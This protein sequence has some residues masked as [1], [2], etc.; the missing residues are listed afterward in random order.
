MK[1]HILDDWFDTLKT[2]PCF[3]RLAD[4]DV[5]IW[6]DHQP[7]PVA[8]AKRV[9][10]AEAL[11]LFRERTRIGADLLG[12]LPK[13]KLISQRSVYPHVDVDACTANGVL[14]CSNMHS[15]TP[16]Y[17]AAEHTLALILASYRQ[18]PQQSASLKAGE[19]QSGV[20]RTLRG[21][22]LGLY[23]YGRIGRAVAEYAR[24]LGMKVQWWAS[25]AGRARA[26]ADGE[27]LAPSRKAFFATSDIVSLHL[28]LKPATKAI[29]TAEDLAAM[30]PRAL[31][32]NTSRSG[33]LAPGTLE[34]ELSKGRIHAAVDVF[35]QEPMTDKNNILLT[36]PNVIATPHIGYVTEDEFDLQFADIFDQINAYADG[37]PIHMINPGVRDQ[38]QD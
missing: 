15:G 11:V 23:G 3:D 6:T 30:S 22:T 9:Q 34:A 26:L 7:D 37:Q 29:V 2:L 27:T 8:L 25:E 24:A 12:R 36:H 1:V 13:L 19:W 16:S 35:D 20:G 28:R 4:H 33:L 5:T 18:I 38:T 17:A 32:V 10:E 21:R 31:L 14:L